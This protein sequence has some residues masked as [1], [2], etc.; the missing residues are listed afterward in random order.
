MDKTM[1]DGLAKHA[2]QLGF[3]SL[4]A[5]MRFLA[6]A[7]I[8]GRRIDLDADSWGQPSQ[9][10]MARWENQLKDLPRQLKAGEAKSFDGTEDPLA[11]LRSL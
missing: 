7:D 3:D 10:A 1:R 2:E 4:Q 8:D 5:Y 9:K 11:Y 6:K